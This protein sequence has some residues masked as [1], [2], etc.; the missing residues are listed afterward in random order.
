MK[1]VRNPIVPGSNVTNHCLAS[2]QSAAFF[3]FIA[4]QDDDSG[5]QQKLTHGSRKYLV[6]RVTALSRLQAKSQRNDSADSRPRDL[7]HH[8]HR[9]PYREHRDRDF[10]P[11]ADLALRDD[12][13]ASM[14][15]G[16]PGAPA[17][18]TG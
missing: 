18:R 14:A 17:M 5:R 3:R 16:Q 2:V 13:P 10:P 4:L 11:A 6:L 1:S 8:R 9:R 15:P 12:A 7:L